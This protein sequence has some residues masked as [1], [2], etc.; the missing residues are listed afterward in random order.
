MSID[1]AALLAAL[2]Q[3]LLVVDGSGLVTY[4]NGHAERLLGFKS[5]SLIG[6]QL[7]ELPFFVLSEAGQALDP[8]G[9]PLERARTTREACARRIGVVRDSGDT[10]WVEVD[11]APLP[12]GGAVATFTDATARKAAE[13]RATSMLRTAQDGV[14]LLDDELHFLEVNEAACRMLGYSRDA[15]LCMQV[16]EI[17][18]VESA[19]ETLHHAE[20]VQQR[21]YDRFE[22]RHRRRDGAIFPVEVSVTWQAESRQMVVFV[23]DITEQLRSEADLACSE[24]R[25]HGLFTSLQEGFAL[26]EIII[27][28]NGKPFDYRYLEVNP[29]FEAMTGIPRAGWIGHTI[30]EV[31]PGI[32]PQWIEVF[33]RVALTGE[34]AVVEEEAAA[35]G[36]AYRVVVYRPAPMQFAILATDITDQREA[37]E[38]LRVSEQKFVGLFHAS[39]DAIALSRPSDGVYLDVNPGFTEL[40][41]FQSAEVIGHSS[42]P[43]DLSIWIDPEE[44]DA[45]VLALKE[46]GEVLDFEAR[47]RH[48]DGRELVCLFSASMLRIQGEEL[49]LSTARDISSRKAAEQ[50]LQNSEERLRTLINAMQD[51]VVFKNGDGRWM[52]LNTFGQRLFGLKDEA[53]RGCPE[54]ALPLDHGRFAGVLEMC[55]ST[56]EVAWSKAEPYRC[57]EWFPDEWGHERT[58]DVIKVPLFHP[59]GSRKGLVVMGRDISERQRMLADLRLTNNHLAGVLKALPDLLLILDREDRVQAIHAPEDLPLLLPESEAL[60]H[61]LDEFLPIELGAQAGEVL[62]RLR[63]GRSC[64]WLEYSLPAGRLGERQHFEARFTAAE[65]GTVVILVRNMT[66]RIEA[67]QALR[68]SE[69][70]LLMVTEHA[71][72]SILQ[73]SCEGRIL[74]INRVVEG[75]RRE[76]VIGQDWM[77]WMPEGDARETAQ[78]ALDEAVATGRQMDYRVQ[79]AGA[80]GALRW[81]QARLSP[82]VEEGR[83]TSL[84]VFSTDITEHRKSEEERLRLEQQVNR[85]QKMESLGSL[86]GGVAHDMNN[87]LGAILGLSTAMRVQEPDGTRLARTLDTIVTACE[88]GGTLVRGLLNFTRQRLA[89]EK[90]LD[91]NHLVREEVLLL[92]RTTLQRV[93]LLMELDPQLKFVVGDGSSL[94]HALM[95]LCVNAVDAMPDGGVLTLQT[96]NL[97]DDRV[98]LLVED[99][100]TGMTPEVLEKAQDPFF[101]TKPVGKGTGL[102][103]SIVYGTMKAHHG[104]MEIWSKPGRGTRVELTFPA[105]IPPEPAIPVPQQ[106]PGH[107]P[108]HLLL[109]DDD[110]LVQASMEALLGALGCKLDVVSSGEEALVRFELGF[111][112]DAVILDMN[113]PGLGGEGTLP[114][115][116]ALQPN[117]PVLLAT[118]RA[119]QR[120][121]DLVATYAHVTMLPKPFGLTELRDQLKRISI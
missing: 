35:L 23:R 68:S 99:S 47:V 32:E 21:G 72:D 84:I 2:P 65:E 108:L 94:S 29:A 100:G 24:A 42:L 36:R 111:T 97:G 30:R 96:R 73:I 17:E 78:R 25:F 116:R 63:Q 105:A 48:R 70:R 7:T 10:F 102:G 119:D 93:R 98:Q 67:E 101:T 11:A 37:S 62:R 107:A 110:E 75:I 3:A 38:A 56:D 46:H 95:N 54:A 114:R 1:P 26:H 104:R 87:V 40:T 41:G 88:R 61:R 19:A 90:A 121:L 9:W 109:V 64:E 79:G 16:N 91:L 6:S 28:T 55:R 120:V 44:R 34:P 82:V 92:E 69:A 83:V 86:A 50:N 22:T 106:P 49:L 14:W 27:D 31:L 89:E 15:M 77:Q 81:Y 5:E 112:C 45:V 118:G 8:M 113:M 71:P 76:D 52:E 33:G 57:E 59:D 51:L 85:A 115:L 20:V 117:L 103:L 13:D 60:G 80:H 53:F 43:G 39:P 4:L 66:A 58:F 18:V 74:Y 12:G